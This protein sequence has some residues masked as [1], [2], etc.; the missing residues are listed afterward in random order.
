MFLSQAWNQSMRQNSKAYFLAV[1]V[2]TGQ[3]DANSDLLLMAGG[4]GH[5]WGYSST[6]LLVPHSLLISLYWGALNKVFR[7]HLFF[8]QSAL[9]VSFIGGVADTALSELMSLDWCWTCTDKVARS[10][11]K[12]NSRKDRGQKRKSNKTDSRRYCEVDSL[13]LLHIILRSYG[14][15]NF[16]HPHVG[17]RRIMGAD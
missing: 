5:I 2:K 14:T 6:S 10:Q 12:H 15:F 17:M 3:G 1:R 8:S 4:A 16:I 13:N 9:T 7:K 11:N